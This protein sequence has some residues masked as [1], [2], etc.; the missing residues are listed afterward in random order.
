MRHSIFS[1]LQKLTEY[2]NKEFKDGGH[3]AS[4]NSLKYFNDLSDT[5]QTNKSF[6]SSIQHK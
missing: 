4:L 2:R 6:F 3:L 1:D 5:T